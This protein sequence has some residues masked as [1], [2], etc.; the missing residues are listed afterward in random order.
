MVLQHVADPARV[1]QDPWAQPAGQICTAHNYMII[2]QT[3]GRDI[4]VSAWYEG[5]TSVADM[6][7]P[8]KT[9]EIGFFDA[10]SNPDSSNVWSSYWYNGFIYANDEGRGLDTLAFNDARAEN[11]VELPFFNPQTQ[12]NVIPPDPAHL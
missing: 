4:L 10:Q 12:M 5:G 9:A 3:G 6:T 11:T 7:N 2:P 8:A 1:V